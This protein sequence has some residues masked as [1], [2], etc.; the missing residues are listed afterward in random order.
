VKV[1][2]TGSTGLLGSTLLRQAPSHI[3]LGASYNVN[4]LVPN[5]SCRYFYADITRKNLIAKA[6]S[7]FKPDVVIHTAAI[8]TP[9]YCDKHK[10]EAYRVNVVGTKNIIKEC[11]KNNVVLVYITTNGVYDGE[12]PPYDESIKPKP[13]DF[14]G[15][16][17]YQSEKLVMQSK[18]PY[19]IIRLI[20]MYGWN[21]PFERQNP[22]TW[23]L[24]ILGR[25]KT[26]INMV[27]DMFCNFLF[28]EEA[29]KAIWKSILSKQ[30]GESFNIAGKNCQSRFDFTREIAK[31]FG[32]DQRMIYP[33]TLNFF[34][35]F[36]PRPKNTCFITNKM[37]KV[38]KIKP[39]NT[40]KG[41]RHMKNNPISEA[42]WKEIR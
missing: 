3:E 33:V 29:S 14:Y 16:T 9:D 2:I 23:L 41:L 24:E 6:F 37:E 13:I 40:T 42:F 19:I 11:R 28:V 22:V 32:L 25:N 4:K 17:K 1:F 36:V 38:L 5:V 21:N 20:T 27:T 39:I 8:A 12:Y 15:K 31:V 35:Y 18:V 7:S 34:K 26:P 10:E 30:W